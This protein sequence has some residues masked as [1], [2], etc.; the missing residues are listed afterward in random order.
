MQSVNLA[1]P[2]AALCSMS[3]KKSIRASPVPC[4]SQRAARVASRSTRQ[5]VQASVEAE[6]G[7]RA[8]LVSAAAAA[9]TVNLGGAAPV[10]AGNIP[11]GFTAITDTLKGY[12]FLCPFGWQEVSVDGIDAVYKDVIE[13]LESVSLTIIPTKTPSIAE[14]GTPEAVANTLIANVLTTPGQSPTLIQASQREVE[15]KTY[16]N[17]EFTAK[18]GPLTRHQLATCSISQGKFFTL[19]TGA[20][21]RRWNKMKPKLEIVA[22]SF[23]NLY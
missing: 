14:L 22:K 5:V 7:R 9:L 20:N 6:T 8:A 15:G 18:L 23:Y 13:P 3:A 19:T 4:K 12:A 16:Y 2:A 1:A 10:L 21:E 11:S 17:F